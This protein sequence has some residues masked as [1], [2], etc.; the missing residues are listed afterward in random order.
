MERIVATAVCAEYGSAFVWCFPVRAV[1]G[2]GCEMNDVAALS[3]QVQHWLCA[4]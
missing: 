1:A 2:E 3:M 4:D